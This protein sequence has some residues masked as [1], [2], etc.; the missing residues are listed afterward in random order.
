MARVETTNDVSP[1]IGAMLWGFVFW[2]S[3]GPFGTERQPRTLKDFQQKH[4]ANAAVAM[5]AKAEAS[6][7]LKRMR[8]PGG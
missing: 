8:K 6:G 4:N 2:S 3:T 7:T 5:E 1:H